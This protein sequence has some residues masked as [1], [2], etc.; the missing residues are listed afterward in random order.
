MSFLAE[1]CSVTNLTPQIDNFKFFCYINLHVNVNMACRSITKGCSKS[2]S[3]AHVF[4]QVAPRRSFQT[5]PQPVL[6]FLLPNTSPTPT[7]SIRTRKQAFRKPQNTRTFA[8]SAARR[9]TIVVVNPK[10]DDDGND[11]TVE[12]TPRASNVRAIHSLT[13]VYSNNS[14]AFKRN[15][16]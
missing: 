1:V 10:Q 15:H 2:L 14:A 9:A 16:V 13:F 11:M 3:S 8:S 12:I 5:A 4:L 7:R 6:D